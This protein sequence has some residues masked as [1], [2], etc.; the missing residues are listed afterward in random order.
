MDK[1]HWP[2]GLPDIKNNA[3]LHNK[4]YDYGNNKSM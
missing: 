1:Y 3:R 4:T 2:S